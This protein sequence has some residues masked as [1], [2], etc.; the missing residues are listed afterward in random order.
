VDN[1]SSD[2]EEL[3]ALF[4]VHNVRAVIVGGHALAFH[5]RPRYTNDLDI[6]LE[7]S[8]TNAA[9]LMRA[10]EDF[11]F[12][13]VGLTPQD[14]SSP[15]KIVQ[16]GVAPNRI[17]LMTAIDGVTFDE[18]WADRV[19]GTFGSVPVSFLGRRTFLDNK[20][21]AGRPQDIADIDAIS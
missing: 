4:N 6:F 10:L 16:L 21:A 19:H 14:F 20:R 3:L 15:G 5:G 11:G 1:L 12:G 2:F 9:A 17:D 18:A 13:S 7:P 8:A